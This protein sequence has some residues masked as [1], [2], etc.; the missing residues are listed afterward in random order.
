MVFGEGYMASQVADDYRSYAD[1]DVYQSKNYYAVVT[2]PPDGWLGSGADEGRAKQRYA[3]GRR[4][5][6]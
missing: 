6:P 4:K 2:P 3:W 1:L 5:E